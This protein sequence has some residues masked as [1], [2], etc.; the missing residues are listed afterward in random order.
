MPKA[1]SNNL[2]DLMVGIRKDHGDRALIESTEEYYSVEKMPTGIL[3]L[4]KELEGGIA[5][6]RMTEMFGPESG[7]K[8]GL[9]LS[10][11][12][13]VLA[14]GKKV[15]YMNL[16]NGFD[17]VLARKCGVDPDL[18]HFSEPE[19]AE[20]VFEI[21][22]LLVTADDLGLIIV[23]SVAAMVPRAEIEGDYGD[24]HVGV[25]ARIM[26]AGLKKLNR[27]MQEVDSQVSVIWINQIR[28]TIGGFGYGPKTT[29]T[30]GRGLKF[31]CGTRLNVARVGSVKQGEDVIGHKVQVKIDKN[32]YAPQ[33]RKAEFDIIY[34]TGISNESTILDLAVEKGLV[35]KSGSWYA[36]ATTGE[37][38][39][40]GKLAVL[41]KLRQ[42]PDLANRLVEACNA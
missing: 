16:E 10:V 9:S 39:G 4:D 24:S 11:A 6:G 29:T 15:V 13:Q 25:M 35:K 42:E 2:D 33:F 30:G 5:V 36:D 23:D 38:L 7:G 19:T 18:L 1:K 12:A 21:I 14:R 32:R 37:Q 28:E 26:S 22:E 41:E 20:E 8:T 3:A 40:Q 34:A 17:P 31:Y 27:Y